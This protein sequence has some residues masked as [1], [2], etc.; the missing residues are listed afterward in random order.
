[1]KLM[2]KLDYEGLWVFWLNCN[3][4]TQEYND[5]D[6]FMLKIVLH[7]YASFILIACPWDAE[8]ILITSTLVIAH[9]LSITFVFHD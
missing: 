3:D 8:L 9:I 4:N 6:D 2:Q 7:T 5:N 1:M